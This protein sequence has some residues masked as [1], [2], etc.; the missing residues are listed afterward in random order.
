MSH[1]P[2]DTAFWGELPNSVI[3]TWIIETLKKI[4]KNQKQL[5]PRTQIYRTKN[6]A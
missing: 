5:S 1:N 6:S 2:F 3:Y 4:E